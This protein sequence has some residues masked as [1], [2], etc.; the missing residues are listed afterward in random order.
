MVAHQNRVWETEKANVAAPLDDGRRALKKLLADHLLKAAD[1]KRF[2]IQQK[3]FE[4]GESAGHQLATI[5][6]SQQTSTHIT[7]L[8]SSK[9]VAYIL[10]V[11]LA[12]FKTLY[13]SRFSG[14]EEGLATYLDNIPLP[15]LSAQSRQS[16]EKTISCSKLEEA[17]Q[18]APNEKAPG[19]DGL[20]AEFFKQH[21]EILLPYLLEVLQEAM[22]TAS[23]PASMIK[24][25]IVLLPKPGKDP[26]SPN[27]GQSSFSRLMLSSWR[28]Y[29]LIG[30]VKLSL[31]WCM[32]IRPDLCQINLLR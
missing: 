4:Q 2:F 23:L 7:K 17:L 29:W 28:R 14:S 5:I 25:I 20:P 10:R 32:G 12:Y 15:I 9:G 24:A 3:Y 26:I 31:K 18:S 27:I 16:L 30:L 19:S 11:L 1:N 22:G 21:R 6:C 8:V 13:T